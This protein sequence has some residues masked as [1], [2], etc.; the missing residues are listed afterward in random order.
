[1]RRSF[2]FQRRA[3]SSPRGACVSRLIGNSDIT[4]NPR[5][6]QADPSSNLRGLANCRWP[7]ACRSTLQTQEAPLSLEWR[8]AVPSWSL[9]SQHLRT[10][11]FTVPAAWL[12]AGLPLEGRSNG[13]CSCRTPASLW[14]GRILPISRYITG[15]LLLALC[16][17][18]Q[19]SLFF[20]YLA[21]FLG[22][23]HFDSGRPIRASILKTISTSTI[24]GIADR[25]G[26]P[27][28]P[29]QSA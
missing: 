18:N 25:N 11:Y 10:V 8:F 21:N 19:S 2:L 28:Q 6:W 4:A 1:M 27:F 26:F 7:Q 22:P 3:C 9:A 16:V 13:G 15:T 29:E 5:G 12:P 20:N 24:S 14:A 23:N 17:P